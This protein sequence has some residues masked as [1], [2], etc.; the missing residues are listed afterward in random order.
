MIG[1]NINKAKEIWRDKI[2]AARNE[3]LAKLYVLYMRALES[4]NIELQQSIASKKQALRDAP[5]DNRID[6]ANSPEQLK[7]LNII[8]EIMIY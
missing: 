3:E 7:S 6:D 5:A 2:R 8:Q 1:V 4:G